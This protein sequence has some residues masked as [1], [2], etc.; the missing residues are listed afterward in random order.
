[1]EMELGASAF[2]VGSRELHGN[3]SFVEMSDDEK[4]VYETLSDVLTR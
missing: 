1:M 2:S 3:D 4:M